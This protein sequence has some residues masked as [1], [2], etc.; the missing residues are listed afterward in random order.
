MAN[1]RITTAE[2]RTRGPDLDRPLNKPMSAQRRRI[3]RPGEYGEDKVRQVKLMALRGW[4]V[5]EMADC[6]GISTPT[7]YSWAD[8]HPDFS[9]ALK[10]GR[11]AS[12]E[13]VKHSLYAKAV[14][15]TFQS[16]K[17]FQHDGQIIRAPVTEY[18]QPDATSAIF[19]LKN[20]QPK[21]W[22]DQRDVNLSGSVEIKQDDRQLAL[23]MLDLLRGAMDT[24][25][26]IEHNQ[27]K[28]NE[29]ADDQD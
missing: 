2:A 15:Y 19:W 21:E 3:G 13:R 22:R 11:E 8:D 18:V 6:M 16:E 26:T 4:T 29:N 14:G 10:E 12:D 20:R 5:Q 1:Q 28:V 27:E 23:A 7:F 17:I 9:S 24:P 25:V